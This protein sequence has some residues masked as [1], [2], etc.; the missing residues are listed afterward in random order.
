M[1]TGCSTQEILDLNL[2]VQ[3]VLNCCDVMTKK[4]YELEN[5]FKLLCDYMGVKVKGKHYKRRIKPIGL[6]KQ[7]S[8]GDSEDE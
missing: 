5:D 1:N 2:R 6:D 7:L 8:G 3:F 4:H